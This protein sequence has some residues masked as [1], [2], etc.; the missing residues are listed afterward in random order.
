[1]LERPLPESKAIS[2]PNHIN[3]PHR[4]ALVFPPTMLPTG[5][6]LGLAVLAAHLRVLRPKVEVRLFD[7]NLN[8]HT[9]RPRAD[10]PS[11]T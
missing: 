1:M 3:T 2:Q 4:L 5:P 9:S 6:P 10:W 8:Y 7:L 11:R